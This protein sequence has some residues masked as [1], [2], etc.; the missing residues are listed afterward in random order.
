VRFYWLFYSQQ[1]LF[2]SIVTVEREHD[3]HRCVCVRKFSAANM[4]THLNVLATYLGKLSLQPPKMNLKAVMKA[5]KKKKKKK[6]SQALH[7]KGP[8]I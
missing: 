3:I 6:K 5:E 1:Q 8:P 7:L 2:G 4:G